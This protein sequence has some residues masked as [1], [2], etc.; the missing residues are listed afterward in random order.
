[1]PKEENIL[2]QM[3]STIDRWQEAGDDRVIF[4]QC[5]QLMTANVLTAVKQQA[6][7]D[8]EWVSRL[9]HRFADYYFTALSAY[10]RQPNRTPAV[11]RVTFDAAGSAETRTLQNLI[12]GVNAH[13]NYDLVLT[14]VDMLQE[15]WPQLNRAGR[16]Q[17][18]RDH[19]LVND[20]IALTIDRVQDQVIEPSSPPMAFLDAAL[21]PL[22]EWLISSLIGHWR[23]EVWHNALRYLAAARGTEQEAL[24]RQI[25][26]Q[27]LKR[28]Q[29][30]QL[31]GGLL[32]L[33]LLI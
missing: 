29:A 16:T 24:R 21:G 22:D 13:I 18:Y 10:D 14:L 3:Q 9:L 20:V 30:V 23:E 2:A 32:D 19:R 33:R 8:P 25:E 5:Y 28:A 31:N 27:T 17:R 7:N 12:L 11:W 15:D 26:A 1:M 4:L 6:F